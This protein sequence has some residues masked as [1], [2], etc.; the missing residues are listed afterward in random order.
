MVAERR[1][2]AWEAKARR[3]G[4]VSAAALAAC[5]GAAV[6]A[7]AE[8]RLAVARGLQVREAEVRERRRQREAG[9]EARAVRTAADALAREAQALEAEGEPDWLREAGLALSRAGADV[10]ALSDVG[11]ASVAEAEGTTRTRRKKAGARRGE[12]I[13][14]RREVGQS[15]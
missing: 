10:L 6:T 2:A 13:A 9:Q 3:P 4:R 14:A 5:L 15:G 1:L 8:R 7:A 11:V 12:T